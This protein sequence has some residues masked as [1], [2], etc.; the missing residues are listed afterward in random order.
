[1]ERY[2]FA[3]LYYFRDN[4][5]M[6]C[7]NAQELQVLFPPLKKFFPDIEFED[8]KLPSGE[9]YWMMGLRQNWDGHEGEALWWL[10]RQLCARGWEPLTPNTTHSANVAYV[11]KRRVEG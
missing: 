4:V 3:E 1:M 6:H 2:E 8:A 5:C 11:F 7:T 10:L 9:T